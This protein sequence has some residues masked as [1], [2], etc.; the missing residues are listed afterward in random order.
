MTGSLF[1]V[2]L[3]AVIVA[4]H[5]DGPFAIKTAASCLVLS[6][7]FRIAEQVLL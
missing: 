4:P 3:G 5:V 2:L 6:A 7:V 1:F